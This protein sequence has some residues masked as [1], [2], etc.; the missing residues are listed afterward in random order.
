[1]EF[2]ELLRWRQTWRGASRLLSRALLPKPSIKATTNRSWRAARA[3]YQPGS[4]ILRMSKTQMVRALAGNNS[5]PRTGTRAG[6]LLTAAYFSRIVGSL[7]GCSHWT[8]L[9]R[10]A[11]LTFVPTAISRL[12]L[13]DFHSRVSKASQE[14]LSFRRNTCPLTS[15]QCRSAFLI[16]FISSGSVRH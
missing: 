3:T 14:R 8:P 7:H 15:R 5:W 6:T 4:H 13:R 1:M 9:H 2:T 16:V 12:G 10:V 11:L